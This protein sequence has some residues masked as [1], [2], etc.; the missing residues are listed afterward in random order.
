VEIPAWAETLFEKVVVV[1]ETPASD[2]LE[3]A[4]S[5]DLLPWIDSLLVEIPL[6]IENVK[7][8]VFPASF[9]TNVMGFSQETLTKLPG[10]LKA[11]RTGSSRTRSAPA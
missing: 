5:M 1:F 4:G 7:A 6:L 11:Y 8:N 9:L 10:L 3:A 2:T